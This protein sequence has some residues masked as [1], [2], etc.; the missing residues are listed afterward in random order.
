M[1]LEGRGGSCC[2]SVSLAAL[3][4][5]CGWSAPVLAQD[6]GTGGEA[7][8]SGIQEIIVTAQKRSQR[9]SDV[10]ISI[11]AQTAEQLKSAGVVDVSQLAKVA[12]GFTASES[13]NGFPIFSI[14]GVNF[15]SNQISAAPTVS[16]YV[17]EAALP[18]PAMTGAMLLDVERIEVLKGPQGTLFGQNATGGSINVIAAKPTSTLE[19]GGHGEVNNFGQV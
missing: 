11:V 12:P 10:G 9:L 18:L 15:N 3:I 8:D 14:R 7:T 17:D 4:A 5:A 1:K 19:V 13:Q 6:A 16:T 2:V